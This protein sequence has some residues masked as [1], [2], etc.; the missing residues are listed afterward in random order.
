MV[1]LHKGMVGLTWYTGAAGLMDQLVIESF[2][3]LKKKGDR[4]HF[5]PR[6]P[7]AWKT[8]SMSYRFINTLYQISFNQVTGKNEI[9]KILIDGNEKA[10]KHIPLTNDGITHTVEVFFEVVRY[11]ERGFYCS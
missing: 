6:V 1:P 10:D 4:L 7:A 9:L 8:F 11:I 2:I 3:G 5:E